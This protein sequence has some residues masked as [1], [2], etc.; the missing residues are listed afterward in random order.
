MS[1]VDELNRLDGII[2]I[3]ATSVMELAL[4]V[5]LLRKALEEIADLESVRMDECGTIATR[6]L[7]GLSGIALQK[8]WLLST[9]DHQPTG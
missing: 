8:S 1:A 7:D 5:R 6:A 2:P 4:A 3:T 9:N